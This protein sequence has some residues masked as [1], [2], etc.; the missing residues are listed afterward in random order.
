MFAKTTVLFGD[1]VAEALGGSV[2]D[3]LGFLIGEHRLGEG[4]FELTPDDFH[5]MKLFHNTHAMPPWV[6]TATLILDEPCVDYGREQKEKRLGC[7]ITW[8]RSGRG[9]VIANDRHDNR[10]R[11]WHIGCWHE[12]ESKTVG[13]CLTKY[14]CKKCGWAKTIDSGD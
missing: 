10:F 12:Y 7:F 2:P 1:Q 5:K 8:Y 14:T 11:M 6:G 3:A 9:I 13:N 4:S